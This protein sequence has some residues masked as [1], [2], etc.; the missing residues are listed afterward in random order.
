MNAPKLMGQ[1][2]NRRPRHARR[3]FRRTEG[4][5]PGTDDRPRPFRRADTLACGQRHRWQSREDG[6]NEDVG[7]TWL[8]RVRM[9]E[10]GIES[11]GASDG[12]AMRVWLH[13]PATA[14]CWNGGG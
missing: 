8:I 1:L 7:D 10:I 3:P 11:I 6:W 5:N 2:A 4:K 12:N 9:T 14:S 13:P